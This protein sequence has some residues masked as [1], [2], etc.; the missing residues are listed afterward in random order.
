MSGSL[1]IEVRVSSAATVAILQVLRAATGETLASLEPKLRRA[2]P[3]YSV[4]LIPEAFYS[5]IEA[6]LAFIAA[7]ERLPAQYSIEANGRGIDRSALQ[8][9]KFQVDHMGPE[10]FR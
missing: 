3:V 5:G 10:D 1:A 7:V 9:I 2:E 6:L 8:Q 4:V